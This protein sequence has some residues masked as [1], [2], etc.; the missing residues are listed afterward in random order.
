MSNIIR[1]ELKKT[2]KCKPIYCSIIIVFALTIFINL[3]I[4]LKMN[5]VTRYALPINTVYIFS[6]MLIFTIFLSISSYILGIEYKFDT[7][8]IMKTKKALEG[9]IL[10]SKIVALILA[11]LMVL[12]MAFTLILYLIAK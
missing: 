8:K 12:S 6:S 10:I 11:G 9:E 2:F 4:A 1:Y 7:M 3:F 5:G